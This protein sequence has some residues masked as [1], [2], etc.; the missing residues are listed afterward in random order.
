MLEMLKSRTII[1]AAV[2]IGFT[3]LN[4]LNVLPADLTQDMVVN[5]IYGVILVAVVFF[6]KNAKAAL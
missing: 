3:I 1:A 6:R 5:A 4:A 2:G